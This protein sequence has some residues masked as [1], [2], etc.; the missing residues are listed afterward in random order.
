MNE[1]VFM[2]TDNSLILPDGRKLAYAEFGQPGGYPVL[3]FHG[4]PSS[5]LEPLMLGDDIFS[6]FGLRVICPDRPGMGQSDFQSRR[7]F[8]DW[9]AD[10]VFLTEALGL[11]QISVLGVSGGGG[12]AAVCA[13]KIPERLS[14]VVIASGA[15]RIDSEAARRIGFPMNSMWQVTIRTPFFLPGV[16]Y[17][18][19]KMM[20]KPPKNGS[21]RVSTPPNSILPA[22]DYAVMTQPGRIEINQRILSEVM[23]QGSKGPVWD[24]RLIAREW[25]FDLAEIRSPL[26]LFHG[27]QDRNFPV[28]LVRQFVHRLPCAE[29]ITYPEDGHISTHINHFDEVVKALIP[30]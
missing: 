5:R 22:A 2:K 20:S 10:M 29:L 12:Y 24:M 17:M 21:E 13:A 18:M 11:N 9:P 6:Q 4:A 14:K 8:S 25:D 30:G 28:D 19:N 16:L 1:G 26:T 7:G 27:E 3:Y 15:W 23:R